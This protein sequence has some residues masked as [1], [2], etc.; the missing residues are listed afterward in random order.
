MYEV[1]DLRVDALR[2]DSS[3]YVACLQQLCVLTNLP[4][5]SHVYEMAI[6]N[7]VPLC[8][9]VSSF[10][11]DQ[12]Q[13]ELFEMILVRATVDDNKEMNSRPDQYHFK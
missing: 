5:L 8:D 3:N 1:Q 6:Q 11:I 9:N 10:P 12:L 2:W 4:I 7:P 13:F